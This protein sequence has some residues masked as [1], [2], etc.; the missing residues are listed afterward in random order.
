MA[1]INKLTE[2]DV[3][4]ARTFLKFLAD[5]K[6]ID[7][8]AD[9]LKAKGIGSLFVSVEVIQEIQSFIQA[10]FSARGGV[11]ASAQAVI[12]SAHQNNRC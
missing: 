7:K 3:D 9:H 11:T 8:A 12:L 5:E 1:D 6:L 2:A 10:E 4:R